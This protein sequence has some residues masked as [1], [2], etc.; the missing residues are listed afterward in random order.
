MRS[1]NPMLLGAALI[2]SALLAGPASPD[3]IK[4]LQPDGSVI[5]AR[6]CGDEFQ[7]WVETE[8]GYTIIKN[9]KTGIWE[10]GLLDGRTGQIQ[11]SGQGV[12]QATQPPASLEKHLRPVRNLD[13]ETLHLK[14][15]Q[16]AQAERWNISPKGL[17]AGPQ[18]E[19]GAVSGT[20][21]LI[22]FLVS[23]SDRSLTTT[24]AGWNSVIFQ[25]GSGVKSVRQF[26][27]DNSFNSLD[28]TPIP[29]TQAGNPAG[30]VSVTLPTPHPNYGKNYDYTTETTWLNA[31]LAQAAPYVDFAALDTNGD[32]TITTSEA[33]FYFIAAGYE[34]SGSS[35]TPN[36]WAHAWGGGIT[37][38]TK[39]VNRWAMNGELNDASRQH[40]MGVIAHELGHSMAGLP[41]LYDTAGS[42]S[43]LGAFSLMANGSWGRDTN[44]D[45]GT[46]PVSLDAWCRQ[47]LLWTSPQLPTTQGQVVTLG[48]CLANPTAAARVQ[49]NA[50]STQEYFL[51]ENRYPTGW[52][53][54]LIRYMGS[55]WPGGL[56]VM[57]V[58]ETIASNAY[59]AGSHQK[60][61]AEHANNAAYGS[62]GTAASLFYAGGSGAS[63]TPATS[64]SS[65]YYSGAS[66]SIG[67]TSASNPGT[68]MTF[69]MFKVTDTTAPTGKPG[70][71]TGTTTSDTATFTWTA[72]DAADPDSGIS[73][74]RLQVGNT[75]GSNNI[76]NSPVGNVLTKTLS[77]LGQQ[78]G[79]PIYA[80]VAAMNG[81]AMDSAWSDA[82]D[83]VTVA[84]PGFD[85]SVLDNTNCSF[86]TIG[87]WTA[88]SSTFYYGSSC[89]Q[90]AAIA[91]NSST[92]LQTR[93]TG[94]GT[95]EFY[96]KILSEPNY[97]FLT[98]SID[99]VDQAGKISGTTAFAK[100]T[101]AIP[102]GSHVVRWTYAKDENTAP[103]GDAAWVDFVTWTSAAMATATITPSAY[104]T[105]TGASVPFTA[106]VSN[107]VSSSNANW[108][109]N[110]TG[111]TFTPPQTASG[112]P[113][114]LA[115]STTPG[116][117][118]LTATPVETPGTPGTALLNLV[119]PASV[120]IGLSRSAATVLLNEPVTFTAT[121]TPLS[122]PSVTWG[123]NGGT[124]GSQNATTASWSSSASGAFTITATSAVA[125]SRSQSASVT[126]L[127][128]ATDISLSV[129]PVTA[130]LV[131][132]KTQTLSG[133]TN[134]GTLAWSLAGQGSLSN[135]SGNTTTYSAP[136]NLLVDTT[137]TVTLSNNAVTPA[138]TVNA[139]I[140]VK[141]LDINRDSAFDLQDVLT[142]ALDWGS[143]TSTRSRLSG[144]T[145]AVG[146]TD[147]N[148]LL[149]SL[150][151]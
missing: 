123:K 47:F 142:L 143:T 130:T 37:A 105:I 80:R 71:P 26:Y 27:Q 144:G 16:Q 51:V 18:A 21:K 87:P 43:G 76:Y 91:D 55:T 31:A 41:D 128:P 138:K 82:S 151:F 102:A 36:L 150:G 29:H 124:F 70:K 88:T 59:V 73:G 122:D 99:G 135:S 79:V 17:A 12:S 30:I 33:V 65:A 93:I 121:V 10:Y 8:A 1:Q 39:T 58:D 132:G 61:M 131:S 5:S 62:L 119:A 95:L 118:T 89:A 110:S 148:L 111:F 50:L 137:A 101:F 56:L 83:A 77:D 92:Y 9:T 100:Q 19:L 63:F 112:S 139:T 113:T 140:T 115:T 120:N 84:L 64:P 125:T 98:F 104:T 45:S 28:V 145:G 3:P 133:A 24:P 44:E 141:T 116:T 53:R 7:G 60:V 117:Y 6:M 25:T 57:H 52:D 11:P 69:S 14:A 15:L 38:G 54:G 106:T 129:S 66:S 136:A 78:D 40:P 67:F 134:Y 74:Y 4:I 2:G 149:T 126:V 107:F 48:N 147:L 85:A 109:I 94:P 42:N 34:N 46:T 90:S 108:T 68:S 72:G 81:A 127:D 146:T 86:K 20:R 75:P 13:N 97:D 96:W 22:I 103:T 49:N 114:T 35:K 32:G 23:F